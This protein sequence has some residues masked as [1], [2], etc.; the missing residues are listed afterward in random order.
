V[1]LCAIGGAKIISGG[2]SLAT[3]PLDHATREAIISKLLQRG[4]LSVPEPGAQE[5]LEDTSVGRETYIAAF[6][7][8]VGDRVR[9]G[10]TELWIEVERDEA[11]HHLVIF[12]C[13]LIPC[14]R[15]MA[16]KLSLVEAS[17]THGTPPMYLIFQQENPFVKAWDRQQIA[18][19]RR[20]SISLSQTHSLLIGQESTR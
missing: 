7:P 2:N 14:R 19:R 6:G 13:H 1:T 20:P 9:L 15:Y 3:G 18:Q 16:T 17:S 8:T 4:F 10:D 5:V 11:S 12:G